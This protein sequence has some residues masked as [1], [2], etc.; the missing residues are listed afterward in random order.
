GFPAIYRYSELAQEREEEP[1]KEL[2]IPLMRTRG[3]IRGM[4][5]SPPRNFASVCTLHA[6]RGF[7][8]IE[9]LVVIG[10]FGIVVTIALHQ[11]KDGELDLSTATQNLVGELRIARANATSRGAHYRVTISSESYSVQ[12]LQDDDGDG[13]WQPTG[14]PQN[15][16]FPNG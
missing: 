4:C 13:V 10:I 11:I 14:S 1:G 6:Q 2:S 5:S 12:R 15:M 8:L 3:F 7:S 16:K 9:L